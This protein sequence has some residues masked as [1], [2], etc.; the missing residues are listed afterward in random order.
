MRIS[1]ND[2]AV[3]GLYFTPDVRLTVSNFKN[4]VCF[5]IQE[6]GESGNRLF[7]PKVS[8]AEIKELIS[9]LQELV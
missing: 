7:I 2:N 9:I 8:Q 1:R 4:E 5:I 3:G 6:Q